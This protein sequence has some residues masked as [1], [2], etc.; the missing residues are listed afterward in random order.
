MFVP[1]GQSPQSLARILRPGAGERIL[2]VGPG[3]G[4]HALPIARNLV[5]GGVLDALDIQ[6]EMLDHLKRRAEKA[7]ITNIVTKQ[8][9]AQSLPYP[10]GTFDGAYMIGTLGEIPDAAAALREL[11]RVLKT[12]GRLVIGEAF[13]DPDYVSLPA[14]EEKAKAAGFFLERA[15]GPRLSYFALF[16]PVAGDTLPLPSDHVLE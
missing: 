1:R 6:P 8:G 10:S 5:P 7:G 14:V 13:I 11:R 4:I 2:E 12:G 16:R 3:P 9:D 15:S